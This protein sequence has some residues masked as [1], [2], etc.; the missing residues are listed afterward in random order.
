MQKL[1]DSIVLQTWKD[2]EVI[3]SDDSPNLD[4]ANLVD[5]YRDKL[6]S[7]HYCHNRPAKGMPA[8]W[9]F[10]IKMCRGEW[11]KI[12]HDDD[13]FTESDSLEKFAN[14][15]KLSNA[16]FIFSAYQN[17]QLNTGALDSSKRLSA[18][19]KKQLEQEPLIL[20]SSNVIGPPSVTMVHRS[21]SD[22]YDERLRWRVDLDYYIRILRQT[23]FVYLDEILVNIGMSDIQITQEVKYQKQVEL[24]EAM[25]IL[26]KYGLASFRNII[27]F[28]SW[29]RLLRNLGVRGFK[30]T[31]SY[32][33]SDKWPEIIRRMINAQS[34]IPVSILKNGLFS[35]LWMTWNYN[36]LV[37][38]KKLERNWK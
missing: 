13:W 4:V 12:M 34:K 33:D 11:L 1:L 8:N 10:A 17:I 27:V 25:I 21:L 14:A 38:R 35:K 2:F 23:R 28:D 6:K 15:A 19:W 18:L 30:D 32:V 22:V 7:I 36:Q 31:S 37:K 5:R 9:N 24:P 3:I 16:K 26:E 29:W 20:M